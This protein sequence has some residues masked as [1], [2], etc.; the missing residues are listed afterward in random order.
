MIVVLEGENVGSGGTRLLLQWVALP[1]AV[2]IGYGAWAAYKHRPEP[3]EG[4]DVTRDQHPDLW[5]EVDRLAASAQTEPPA[6]IVI[7]PE[8]NA[9]VTEVAGSREMLIGL[10]LLATFTVGQLRAVL[11]HEL[12][13]TTPAV[14][15]QR[16]RGRCAAGCCCSRCA[17]GWASCG[18]GSSPRTRACTRWS[19]GRR[20]APPSFA[21]TN[22]RFRRRARR[23]PSRRSGLCC[24][25]NSPGCR[26]RALRPALRPG[27]TPR[28]H[29]RGAPAD[30][31]GQPP[32]DGRR[33]RA[34]HRRGEAGR[35]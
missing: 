26:V 19:R 13:H 23:L 20:R 3:A 33:C 22:C 11:A 17:S 14:T 34:D 35:L 2:A 29:L 8:V 1:L 21:P 18:G 4:V 5:A 32:R 24:A 27:R 25:L 31:R 9:A 30:H 10:P 12:G 28:P 15:P 6:R 16:P 7:V